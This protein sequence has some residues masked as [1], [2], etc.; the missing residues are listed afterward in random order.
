MAKTSFIK[1]ARYFKPFTPNILLVLLMLSCAAMADLYLPTLMA[2]IVDN[3]VV[4]GD[5]AY[6]YKT[7]LLMLIVALGGVGCAMIGMFNSSRV[8][9]GFS[10]R[11]RQ[12]IFGQ[13]EG[14]SLDAFD[15]IGTASLIT[16]S[17]SD[18][19]Q[20]QSA[21]IM[22]LGM[23]VRAPIM[24]V[25]G[26]VMALL[27]DKK[28]AI[29]FFIAVPVLALALF[30]IVRQ[31]IPL[32]RLMQKKMDR[33]NLVI[34]EKLTGI[35][36][37][38]AFD[39]VAFE[40][41]RFDAANKDL[42]ETGLALA[43]LMTL[44]MPMMMIIMNVTVIAVVWF[45]SLRIESG[46]MQVG[47]IMAFIQYALQ[48]LFA[49]MMI[50]MLFVILPR[51]QVSVGRIME[52]LDMA[53]EKDSIQKVRDEK[54]DE[55]FITFED[56][57]FTYDGAEEPAVKNVSFHAAIGETTAIIGSTGS[58]KTTLINLLPRFYD[59]TSGAVR[60]DGQ[61]TCCISREALRAMIGLVPQKAV[62]F[63]GSI[64]DNL[65]F[66][67]E[68]ADEEQ[69]RHAA[70]Q[71]QALEFIDAMDGGMDA[72]LAQGGKNLSGGQRQR[73][74]IARALCRKPRLYIFDDSFSALDFK[75]DAA[76]RQALKE[77]IREAAVIIVAQRVSTIMDADRIVVLDEGRV[78]GVG[79]HETLL[80]SCEVYREIVYSQLS[81]EELA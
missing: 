8:A 57:T 10:R 33:I 54:P 13:V 72:F 70:K 9:I 61:D 50:S 14:Y 30:L 62:L 47:D 55:P 7:G 75:T 67:N 68:Q 76:L 65:R 28:L 25:G 73:L 78:V 48:I 20:V 63:S 17:T 60:I 32:F 24:G 15:R 40:K 4:K 56:V 1:L 38:R 41:E 59:V 16:R 43:R 45:G 44:L 66:G 21:V 52:V 71:A 74:A 22:M 31:G 81:Q 35:R 37:I 27:H 64:A 3:G 26:V 19:Q 79:K 49:L 80:K 42:T 39:R 46:H 29:V 11:L 69:L 2:D 12:A 53:P 5:I 6:I 36:V 34:R 58:G 18:V 23:M 77:E 51:A